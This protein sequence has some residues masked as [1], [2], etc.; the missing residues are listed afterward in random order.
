M[1]ITAELIVNDIKGVEQQ[2][3]QLKAQMAQALGALSVLKTMQEYLDKPEPVVE[4]DK[5]AD[6]SPDKVV[7]ASGMYVE[8]EQPNV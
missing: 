4:P 6:A 2:I 5:P 3:E 1:Q 8:K 7:N